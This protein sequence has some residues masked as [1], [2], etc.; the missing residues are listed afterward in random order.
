MKKRAMILPFALI[1]AMIVGCDNGSSNNNDNNKGTLKEKEEVKGLKLLSI[2]EDI[3]AQYD[4]EEYAKRTQVSSYSYYNRGTS[5]DNNIQLFDPEDYAE[6]QGS[7][8]QSQVSSKKQL[9]KKDVSKQVYT[10]RKDDSSSSGEKKQFDGVLNEEQFFALSSNLGFAV[11]DNK[12]MTV[13]A[14]ENYDYVYFEIDAGYKTSTIDMTYNIYDNDVIIQDSSTTLSVATD[15]AYE[16]HEDQTSKNKG[17][18][19]NR[20]INGTNYFVQII[21][22]LPKDGESEPDLKD[23]EKYSVPN[24]YRVLDRNIDKT[25]VKDYFNF[26]MRSNFVQ[27]LSKSNYEAVDSDGNPTFDKNTQWYSSSKDEN[28]NITLQYNQDIYYEEGTQYAGQ[29]VKQIIY[30]QLDE[31]NRLLKYGYDFEFT[32]YGELLQSYTMVFSYGYTSVGDYQ[33]TDSDK[34]IF[35]YNKYYD[36]GTLVPDVEDGN[37]HD[38]AEALLE[39]VNDTIIAAEIN[40]PTGVVR[41][42]NY[43][44]SLSETYEEESLS[45]TTLYNDNVSVT[46]L[47]QTGTDDSNSIYAESAVI[48]QFNKDGNNY[49]IQ[50]FYG[51]SRYSNGKVTTP[52]SEGNE[53]EIS[54]LDTSVIRDIRKIYKNSKRPNSAVTTKLTASLIPEGI[55][56]ETN[57]TVAEHY[58][59]TLQACIQQSI[60]DG[61]A[62][63]GY[64]YTYK[65]SFRLITK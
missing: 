22:E 64:V 16:T 43:S 1:A 18:V 47:S 11:R 34:V 37:K 25:P 58:V 12:T 19:N 10:P 50:Q 56:E 5:E 31:H 20:D 41:E 36:N 32:Y 9:K 14:Y 48:Q 15:E 49:Q 65:I 6:L 3:S 26:Q 59:L 21:H 55:D 51:T 38:E 62:S 53:P 40:E 8:T 28:G 24:N 23:G 29:G 54:L 57:V 46:Y 52:Y 4:W 39:Q 61:Q 13:H 7:S 17:F 60:S 45:D 35:D 44:Q 2:E 42:Y 63:L 33:E 30:A 27:Y